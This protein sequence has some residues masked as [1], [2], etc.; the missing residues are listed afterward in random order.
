MFK[1]IT[2]IWHSHLRLI[3]LKILWPSCK[4]AARDLDHAKAA[5]MYHCSID[6]AWNSNF[7]SEK[8]QEFVDKLK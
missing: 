2:K 3:D 6:S 1:W 7:S 4:A 8:L 5:F